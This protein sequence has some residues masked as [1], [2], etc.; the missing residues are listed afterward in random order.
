FLENRRPFFVKREVYALLPAVFRGAAH[1]GH[2]RMVPHAAEVGLAVGELGNRSARRHGTLLTALAPSSLP[3]EL[4][5]NDGHAGR[6]ECSDQGPDGG[7][8][9]CVRLPWARPTCVRINAAVNAF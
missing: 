5:G 4:K 1:I 8:I 9:H 6:S 3:R 7:L 2:V